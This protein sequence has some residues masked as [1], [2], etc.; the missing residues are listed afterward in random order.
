MSIDSVKF[1]G[2]HHSHRACTFLATGIV[3][4]LLIPVM[5]VISATMDE[6]P[7]FLAFVGFFALIMSILGIVMSSLSLKERDIYTK[8]SIAA[9]VVNSIAFICYAIMYIKGI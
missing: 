8:D 9:I 3:C 5:A 2:R 4:T 7:I 6:T 1:R